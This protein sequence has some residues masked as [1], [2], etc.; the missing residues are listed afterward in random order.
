MHLLI[1]DLRFAIKSWRKSVVLTAVAVLTVA[2]GVGGTTAIYSIVRGVLWRPLPYS[3]YERLVH[4]FEARP[5]QGPD[6]G[7]LV[8]IPTF[9]DWKRESRLIEDFARVPPGPFVDFILAGKG[10]P[11]E[12]MVN[13]ISADAMRLFG[14]QPLLGRRFEPHDEAAGQDRVF[15]LS[16]SSWQRRF[17]GAEDV[18]GR[19]LTFKRGAYTIIGVMPK[20]F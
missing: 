20:A 13:R 7:V 19:Q 2:L 6:R 17:G 16:Y 15:L 10:R 8:S 5:K 14:T 11:E 12:L 1:Q 4:L 9:E 3:N 18:I